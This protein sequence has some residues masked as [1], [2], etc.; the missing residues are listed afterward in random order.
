MSDDDDS[1]FR[2]AMMATRR[3]GRGGKQSKI[4]TPCLHENVSSV[5]MMMMM[6]MMMMTAMM[7][8]EQM[9]NLFRSSH[10]CMPVYLCVSVCL[11]ICLCV[12]MCAG[13]CVFG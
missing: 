1:A 3:E 7:R 4:M 2:L 13:V 6:M 11:F 8:M 12:F 9:V 5:A 10:P